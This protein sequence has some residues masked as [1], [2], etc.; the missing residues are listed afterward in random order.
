MSITNFCIAYGG[1]TTTCPPGHT[2]ASLRK[3]I[4]VGAG[5]I[6][7]EVRTTR[8]GEMVCWHSMQ[9][10][11]ADEPVYL[12][13]HSLDQWRGITESDE[14][15]I[16][17]LD[18]AL[19]LISQTGYGIFVDICVPGIENA[20]ARKLRRFGLP[21]DSMVVVTTNDASRTVMRSM[22]P[23]LTLAHRFRMDHAKIGG[24]LLLDL[25]ADAVV[26]PGPEITVEIANTLKERGIAIYG[27]PVVLGEEMRRL[28]N[29]CCVDGVV[30]PCPELC[31]SLFEAPSSRPDSLQAAA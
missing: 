11:V 27:G 31:L 13:E 2:M 17:S 29:K 3:A 15:P 10:L 9:R 20:L 22:D 25:D 14:A 4:E 26:W 19:T 8:D 1:A 30:T 5:A 6:Y 21:Y 7:V 28:R 23:K 16:V 24:K 18:E 12:T